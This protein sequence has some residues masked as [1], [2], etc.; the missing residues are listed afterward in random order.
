MRNRVEDPVPFGREI[1]IGV[2]IIG[3]GLLILLSALLH[4]SLFS[5]ICPLFL[6]ALGAGLIIR[7]GRSEAGAV[8]R[9]T[10]IGDMRLRRGVPI[11]DHEIWVGVAD[12]DLDLAPDD[13]RPGETVFRIYG[14]VGDLDLRVPEGVGVSIWS[15]AFVTDAKVFGEQ[16]TSILSP[17]SFSTDGYA[18]AESKVRLE[19]LAFVTD[20]KVR[21]MPGSARPGHAARA[22]G[23]ALPL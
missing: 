7:L 4:V 11:A 3:V 13:L 2:A 16:Q 23:A 5:I 6:I 18:E 14:F 15:L 10:P 12:I 21:R 9:V 17:I 19:A 22:G 1:L 20:L 8:F